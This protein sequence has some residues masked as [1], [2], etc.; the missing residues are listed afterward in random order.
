MIKT[1]L[2][3]VLK[4]GT[5]CLCRIFGYNLYFISTDKILIEQPQFHYVLRLV[6]GIAEND[7]QY[8]DVKLY[9]VY[10]SECLD[11]KKRKS[12]NFP[13]SPRFFTW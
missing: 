4:L 2:Y 11:F 3:L 13:I 6:L 8:Y 5:D 7:L 9:I 12:V 10:Y 1:L